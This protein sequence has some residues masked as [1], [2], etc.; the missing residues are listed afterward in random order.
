[1]SERD[2][3]EASVSE[4]ET[5]EIIAKYAEKYDLSKEVLQEIYNEEKAVV[6][7]DRRSSIY[8]DVDNILRNYVKELQAE[9]DAE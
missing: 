1:M 2:S 6:G 5:L 3:Q 4:E 7:M 8:K 9:A